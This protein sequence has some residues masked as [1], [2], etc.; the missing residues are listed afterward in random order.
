MNILNIIST[1]LE[2]LYNFKAKGLIPTHSLRR[3]Q[4]PTLQVSKAQP[5]TP[6]N[7]LILNKS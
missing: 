6:E 2:G 7:N 1:I 3:G 5:P 4:S